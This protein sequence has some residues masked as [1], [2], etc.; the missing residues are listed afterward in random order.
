MKIGIIGGGLMGMALARELSSQGHLVSVLEREKQLGG[1]STHQNY[2]PFYWDRFYHVVLP[3]DRFL[4]HFLK[5]ISPELEPRWIRTLTGFYVDR[6]LYSLSTNLEFL[7]FPP[8]S[9]LGKARLAMT[10]LYCARINDWKSLEKISVSDW[11]RKIGGQATWEKMWKPLLLAKLGDNYKRVSAVFIWSYIKRMFSA[12]ESAGNSEQLGYI[13][14]GYR[15]VFSRMEQSVSAAGGNIYT[16]MTVNSITGSKDGGLLLSYDDETKSEH[17]DKVIF[18]SPVSVLRNVA[19]D[20]LIRLEKDG[21]EVEYLGVICMVLVTSKPLVP[22]YIVNI[23]DSRI[24]FTGI[25]GMSNLVSGDETSGRHI[26]FL[27]RYMHSEDPLL[28]TPDEELREQFLE[29]LQLMLPEFDPGDIESVHIHRAKK[30]QPLQVL[31]YSSLVPKVETEHPDFYVL[32]TSQF[33]NNTLNNNEV[34]RFVEEF[35]QEHTTDFSQAG[36]RK[37]STAAS[38]KRAADAVAMQ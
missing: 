30:V 31:N 25:I 18:T 23:A 6:Q 14:G 10:I 19:S 38:L 22:Y 26:T 37:E 32:N 17:F 24:P 29:G 13:P 11:L 1:L 12:R 5:K 7:K 4:I 3:T 36:K 27:P 33:V 21:R 34:I 20:D 2:G 16:G 35:L 9:L 15:A 28:M 8:L